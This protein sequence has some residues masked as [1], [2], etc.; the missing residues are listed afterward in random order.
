MQRA[1]SEKLSNEGPLPPREEYF[2]PMYARIP[3]IFAN[4]VVY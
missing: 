4:F 1:F 2:C 3:I